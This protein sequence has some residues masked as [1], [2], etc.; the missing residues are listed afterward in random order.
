MI[1]PLQGETVSAT[2][3]NDAVEFFLELDELLFTRRRVR[4][5]NGVIFIKANEPLHII[6][7][8]FASVEVELPNGITFGYAIPQRPAEVC[9]PDA[10]G[11]DNPEGIAT[12]ADRPQ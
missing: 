1:V 5:S 6:L 3:W 2:C 8:I 10:I 9:R 4:L 12:K 11:G 7:A